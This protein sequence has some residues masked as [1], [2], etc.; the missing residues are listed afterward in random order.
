MKKYLVAAVLITA[1]VTPAL[2][3]DGLRLPDLPAPRR[4]SRLTSEH[5]GED[6]LLTAYLHVPGE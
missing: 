3:G 5:V 6:V 1:F 4:L 2:A